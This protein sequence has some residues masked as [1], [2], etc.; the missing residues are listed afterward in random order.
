[1]PAF[2]VKRTEGRCHVIAPL[3]FSA[4][5]PTHRSVGAHVT[6]TTGAAVS[7]WVAL[8]RH[9]HVDISP[10]HTGSLYSSISQIRSLSETPSNA[11]AQQRQP[12]CGPENSEKPASRPLSAAAAEAARLCTPRRHP[13]P[14]KDIRLLPRTLTPLRPLCRCARCAELACLIDRHVL[15]SRGEVVDD[16]KLLGAVA[17]AQLSRRSAHGGK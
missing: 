3:V 9:T 11:P 13:R 14:D 2:E 1:D 10:L 8:A 17:R 12:R 15:A 16:R 6:C 4:L 7:G 5:S